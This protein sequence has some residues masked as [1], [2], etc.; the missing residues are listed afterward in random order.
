MLKISG[1]TLYL[2][3]ILYFCSW[4]CRK[5]G[6][7]LDGLRLTGDMRAI[8]DGHLSILWFASITSILSRRCFRLSREELTLLSDF[9]PTFSFI[10]G[11]LAHL[12]RFCRCYANRDAC[13]KLN[14]DSDFFI[15]KGVLLRAPL[16]Y[17]LSVFYLDAVVNLGA[18]QLMKAG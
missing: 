11:S 9:A 15:I 8:S 18:S 13:L 3:S 4:L 16:F 2:A 1:A 12:S 17:C 10:I 7:L 14:L 6:G 5:E